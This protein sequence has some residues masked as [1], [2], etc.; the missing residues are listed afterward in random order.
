MRGLHLAGVAAMLLIAACDRD[1]PTVAPPTPVRV[2]SIESRP[3]A[4]GLHYSASIVPQTQVEVAFKVGGYVEEILKLS[5]GAE[6][7]LLQRGDRVSTGSV[8][9]RIQEQEFQD[10]LDKAEADLARARADLT[11]GTRDFERAKALYATQS[12]T[13]PDYDAARKEYETAQA[14]VK[15]ANAQVDEAKLNLSYCALAAPM[16]GVVLQRNIEIGSLVRLGSVAFVLADVSAVK[17]VFGVPDTMLGQVNIGD[18]L[19]IT[20]ESLPGT[21]FEGRV[22]TVSPDADPQTRLF[23]IEVAIDNRDDRLKTGMVAALKVPA[24]L[25]PE[26]LALVPLEAVVSAGGGSKD[27]AVFIVEA[28]DKQSI[29][30]LRRVKLGNVYG[31]RV[32]VSEGVQA[33][34]EVV[35]MGA[36]MIADGETVKVLR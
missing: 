5:T 4:D 9:A 22:S 32:D 27:Y 6:S 26:N 8:L 36:S 31:N 19:S 13:A 35:V 12:I 21:Q 24:S 30:H 28:K 2:E 17:A 29:V 25:L 23:E 33:G 3:A 16:D 18:T 7:R 20:T 34:E 10:K 15:A 1:E 14:A 11:K